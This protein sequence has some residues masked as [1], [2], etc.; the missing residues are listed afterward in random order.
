MHIYNIG[1]A[2]AGG[3]GP[4]APLLKATF[5]VSC[6]AFAMS[7]APSSIRREGR[8]GERGA[9]SQLIARLRDTTEG[10]K[11]RYSEG[12]ELMCHTRGQCSYR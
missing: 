7:A 3:G 11:G 2:A 10:I 1:I 4:V 8:A 12:A 5:R 9:K 6:P